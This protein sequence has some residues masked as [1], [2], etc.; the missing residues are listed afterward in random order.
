MSQHQPTGGR[1]TARVWIIVASLLLLQGAAVAYLLQRSQDEAGKDPAGKTAVAVAPGAIDGGGVTTPAVTPDTGPPSP[2]PADAAVSPPDTQAPDL[3]VKKQDA[4]A[5]PAV[6]AKPLVAR[7]KTPPRT[8]PGR[9]PRPPRGR[10]ATKARPEKVAPAAISVACAPRARVSVDGQPTGFTPLA[11]SLAPGVHTVEL[12]AKGH[13]RY[14]K[15]LQV[16]AGEKRSLDVVLKA[17]AKSAPVPKPAPV[18]VKKDPTPAPKATPKPATPRK[19]PT[20]KLPRSVRINLYTEEGQRARFGSMV[21]YAVERAV[22]RGVGLSARGTTGA[23]LRYLYTQHKD[24]DAKVKLY[25]R[26]MGYFIAQAL[27]QGKG[28]VG[29]LLL[30]AHRSGRIEKLANAGWKP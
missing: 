10:G 4:A 30:R 6:A 24:E 3:E 22:T 16:A 15:R 12:S 23:L 11:L 5:P 26:T 25:P 8:R 19:I 13:V 17:V 9:R 21:L 29:G 27:V 20:L 14:S 28:G 1:S 2:P 18:V 7:P